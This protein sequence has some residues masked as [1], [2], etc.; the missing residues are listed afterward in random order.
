MRSHV[1]RMPVIPGT[2]PSSLRLT[3]QTS[4]GRSN[5]RRHSA[6]VEHTIAVRSAER[7]PHGMV[8]SRRHDRFQRGRRRRSCH[9]RCNL[10]PRDVWSRQRRKRC[11]P[12]RVGTRHDWAL[13]NNSHQDTTR[14]NRH[15]V[16]TVQLA[17]TKSRQHPHRLF[18]QRSRRCPPR[19]HVPPSFSRT[20]ANSAPI[21]NPSSNLLYNFSR[22]LYLGERHSECWR[23]GAS[24]V[25]WGGREGA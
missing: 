11:I 9:C 23:Q 4:V 15:I 17:I 25:A 24:R 16:T 22:K 5:A 7:S 21:T 20:T 19:S 18:Q 8:Q 1:R 6:V 14:A 13:Q 10:R 3:A 12:R 2:I